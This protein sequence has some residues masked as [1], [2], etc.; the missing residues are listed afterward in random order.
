MIQKWKKRLPQLCDAMSVITLIAIAV[1]ILP[2]FL[3]QIFGYQLFTAAKGCTDPEIGAGSL[4]IVHKTDPAAAEPGE[5]IAYQTA[6]GIG[7][8]K[9]KVNW[10]VEGEFVIDS[11]EEEAE[12]LNPTYQ[13]F[14]GVVVMHFSYLGQYGEFMRTGIGMVYFVLLAACAAMFHILAGRLRELQELSEQKE[15]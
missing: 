10:M 11:D 3:P 9:V 13:Q 12:T 1:L 6:E 4:V 15:E 5:V 2:F 8:G 7:V 14:A